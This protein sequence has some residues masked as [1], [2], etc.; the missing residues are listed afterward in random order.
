MPFKGQ[1]AFISTDEVSSSQLPRIAAHELGHGTFRLYHTFSDKNDYIVPKGTTDNLM[2]YNN[3][4]ELHKY[5][6]DL[7]QA[8]QGMWFTGLIDEEEMAWRN[9]RGKIRSIVELSRFGYA[10]NRNI[11]LSSNN[12]TAYNLTL[13][14]GHEY[15]KL[16]VYIKEDA[17]ISNTQNKF[18]RDIPEQAFDGDKK[19]RFGFG[20]AG[21]R[22]KLEFIT[23]NDNADKLG[24]YIT[25]RET[26]QQ[27]KNAVKDQI[28]NFDKRLID[29]NVMPDGALEAFTNDMR[30]N[31]LKAIAEKDDNDYFAL[32]NR[33]VQSVS[34]DK[35]SSFFDKIQE[36]NIF[37]KL[38]DAM[39]DED[40]AMFIKSATT[41][42]YEQEGL[43]E[44]FRDISHDNLFVHE[45]REGIM[46]ATIT[47]SMFSD[48]DSITIKG[49]IA[50]VY[51]DPSKNGPWEAYEQR[52]TNTTSM[53][54]YSKTVGYCEL[55]GLE[56][57]SD[58]AHLNA[59]MHNGIIPLPAF[60]YYWIYKNQ[61]KEQMLNQLDFAVTIASFAL[62]VGELNAVSKIGRFAFGVKLTGVVKSAINI[63][64]L[65]QKINNYIKTGTNKG[66]EFL[67]KWQEFCL[68]YDISTFDLR[69]INKNQNFFQNLLTAWS[70]GKE[71]LKEDLEDRVASNLETLMQE[72]E[73]KT[74]E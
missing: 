14:D 57:N 43:A 3:G 67:K 49:N 32:A 25:G 44:K 38:D 33:V 28:S 5:Q 6:W 20:H 24:E 53:D 9:V 17:T 4:K 37:Y 55:V 27:W 63:V 48:K 21:E 7:V 12:L 69:T 22:G 52:P 42:Y 66:A 65:N 73:Q 8:P 41:L 34:N 11:K 2:D 40:Y 19:D 31:L 35:I 47:N 45:L 29:I 56:L 46:G 71:L 62:G 58:Y 26:S 51:R 30:V 60:Y 36:E 1:F 64:L 18:T 15:D 10:F 70:V 16:A 13:G 74:Q 68:L 61:K 72:I 39:N 23:S 50:L 54:A 59:N